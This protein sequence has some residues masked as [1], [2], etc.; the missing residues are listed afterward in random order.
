MQVVRAALRRAESKPKYEKI[1]KRT[2]DAPGI[3]RRMLQK[4]VA[5]LEEV[6]LVHIVMGRVARRAA[7]ISHRVRRHGGVPMAFAASFSDL[8]CRRSAVAEHRPWL[9]G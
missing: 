1:P 8:C 9:S 2:L 7:D 5:R 6:L 3:L 4:V